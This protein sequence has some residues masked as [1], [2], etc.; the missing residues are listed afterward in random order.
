MM[1]T[2]TRQCQVDDQH[3]SKGW[4]CVVTAGNTSQEV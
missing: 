4:Q 1:G 2:S 3:T